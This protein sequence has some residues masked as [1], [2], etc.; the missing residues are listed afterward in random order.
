MDF[1]SVTSGNIVAGIKYQVIGGTS[2]VY[3]GVTYNVNDFFTGVTSVT[4]YTK[5]AGTE[6]VT[7]ASEIKTVSIVIDNNFHIGLLDDVSKAVGVS[8]GIDVRVVT[9]DRSISKGGKIIAPNGK[10]IKI[11]Q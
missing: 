4:T 8:V 7:Y 11:L 10:I 9:E 1:Y 6:I 5:T 2:V 3:N